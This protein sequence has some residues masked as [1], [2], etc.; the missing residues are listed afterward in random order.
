M[1]KYPEIK[2]E[3]LM[4]RGFLPTDAPKIQELAGAFEIAEMTLNIPHPY[5]DGMAETWMNSH[6]SEFNS[7]SGV[8][9]AMIELYSGKLVGAVGLT[10]MQRFNRAE[11]GYWVGKPFWGN[12]YATEASKALLKYGFETLQLN[13]IHASH[14][15][16]NPA[17]GRV[18]QKIGM[19][20]EG[21]LKQHALKWDKF[22]DM[23]VYGKLSST[24]QAQ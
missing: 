2:L 4:L 7:G 8:V 22:V 3:R 19:E 9:F 12:G 20:P 10:V 6:Q 15:T 21:V 1:K 24:W 18:M 16:R 23:A 17:S 13:K 11:L 5:L 14:M